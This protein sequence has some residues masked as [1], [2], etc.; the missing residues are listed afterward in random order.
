MTVELI[1]D[2]DCPHV[3]GTRENLMRAFEQL[4]QRSTWCEWERSS[5]GVPAHVARYGSPTV[6]VE[7][8][9]VTATSTPFESSGDCCR[10]YFSIDG[11]P[12]G[13]PETEAIHRA[14]LRS[15]RPRQTLP[16]RSWIGRG[17]A[18]LPAVGIA[19]LPKL[20]C[21]LCWPAYAALV[22]SIGLGY[23]LSAKYLLLLSSV[24][25]L[26]SVVVLGIS[27]LKT[28]RYGPT[29]VAIIAS[30]AILTGKFEL[31]SP[32][33]THAGVAPCLCAR[34]SGTHGRG[35]RQAHPAARIALLRAPDISNESATRERND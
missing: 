14:L 9:D 31:E 15:M 10:L 35:E 16:P 28:R 23:L 3:T 2:K 5:P 20:T 1:Y 6:L 27:G 7:G 32:A 33:T 29:A 13:V 26:V 8:R 22:S 25:L 34:S 21:P 18:S 24:T 4:N 17:L 30:A 19:L 11:S 12:T